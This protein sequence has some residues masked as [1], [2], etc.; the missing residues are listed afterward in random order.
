MNELTLPPSPN[1]YQSTVLATAK[2]GTIAWGSSNSIVIGKKRENI[3][4]RDFF[5]IQDAQIDKVNS[6]AF[7]PNY[8]EEGKNLL[9][10]G[11]EEYIVRVWD[12]DSMSAVSCQMFTDVSKKK[13]NPCLKATKINTKLISFSIFF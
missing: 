10:S 6:L 7:S 8:G 12:L 3:K 9:V 4:K 13:V 2:E 1:W 5:I 11:G